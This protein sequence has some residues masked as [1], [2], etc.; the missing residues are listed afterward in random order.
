[1]RIGLMGET[2]CL[3]ARAFA[4]PLSQTQRR[5]GVEL[6]NTCDYALVVKLQVGS[7][8]RAYNA[9]PGLHSLVFTG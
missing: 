4:A 9:A 5:Y 8:V 6:E 3:I 1:M 2:S 7:K